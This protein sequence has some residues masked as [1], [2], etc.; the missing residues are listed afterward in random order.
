[1]LKRDDWLD[2]AR[3]LDWDLSYVSEKD[4][5]PE[6][7]SGRPW[8]PH[9]EW[10]GWDEPFRTSYPEYVAGQHAKEASVAAVREAVGRVEDYQRLPQGWLE[11]LKLH[12]ATLPLAE[13]AAV[14]GNL[15]A[16]RFG[17]DSA[18]RSAALLGALDEMRHAQIPLLLMHDLVRWDPQF[19]WTHKFFHTNN[20]VAIAAR[21]LADELL[22]ASDAIEFAIATNFVFETGFTNVQFV[23][24]S[25]LA[26]G[27]GDKMFEKMVGSIQSDEARHAQIGAPVLATVVKH[28][29]AYAQHLLDKWFWRSWLLFA[30]V[31]GFAMDYLTPLEHRTSSFKE[32]MHEWVLDQFLRSLDEF[33]LEAPVVL[34]HLP[35]GP[36]QLSPHGLRERVQLPR[37]GLVQ[38]RRAR[39][40]RNAPGC[41]RSIRPRG[42]TSIRSGSASPTAGAPP[43]PATTSP[44]TAPRSCRSA[45][46][47]SWC[48]RTARRAPTPPT[49]W[50]MAGAATSS[51]RAR[52]GGYSSRSRS[53]TPVTRTS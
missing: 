40:R 42:P 53:A 7:Q 30:V 20:W 47:A 25:A 49:F 6:V 37:V 39:A 23:G 19:D 9:A 48:C 36:R 1:M 33:G 5:F 15:R 34:G 4:A 14:V 32:F 31:T 45:I 2:L 18:W 8:L 12:A 44:C 27:V 17:R 51:V 11:G 3:K 28:D 46:S 50:I 10:A 41:A 26:H 35:R 24:L 21:H 22:L 13:F 16:A 52:A 29:R 38:L 43:I